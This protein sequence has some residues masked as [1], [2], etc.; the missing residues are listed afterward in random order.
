MNSRENL[1]VIVGPTAVGKTAISIKLAKILNGEI[2]SADSMQIYKYM[3]IGT[4][5][6]TPEEM[7]GIPHYLI[8]VVYPDE[9]F[10]VAD[11]KELAEKIISDINKK[12]KIPIVV[13]GTGLYVN[14]LV[15]DLNFT[16]VPPNEKIRKRLNEL[17]DKFGNE[18]IHNMLE[19]IDKESSKRIHVSDRKRIIRAIE[20]YEVTG[21]PMSEQ[22]RDFRKQNDRYNLAMIGLNMDRDKLYERINMRVD[23]MIEN[24]LI[25][26]VANLLK[27]GYTKELTSMQ[28]IGYKEIIKYLEGEL[29]LEE[30][31]ELIKKGSR[32]YAKRQLT[33]FR[34]D[35]RIK[36]FNLD[37][38]S[39]LD[40]LVN[41]I[42]NYVEKILR[43]E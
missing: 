30:S 35:S 27:M 31:I 12:G 9:E 5:K 37:E 21:I 10:T 4:A 29:T 28:G 34:R 20:I 40:I 6:V 18:Y 25:A 14:S 22:N 24:G 19:K 1:M 38:Y 41:Q 11:Y 32:N 43:R 36:W 7:E 16:K 42:V 8:D 13:G 15:Y 17:A 23:K 39:N 33:W 2:I 26:E 3:D